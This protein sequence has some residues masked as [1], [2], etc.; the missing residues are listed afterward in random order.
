MGRLRTGADSF[1]V[2]QGAVDRD[3]RRRPRAGP[4]GR[5]RLARARQ[6]RRR[7]GLAGRRRRARRHPRS[8]RR[9]RTRR[10]CRR[11]S[12]CTSA[13]VRSLRNRA[14]SPWRSRSWPKRS[15]AHRA[16]WPD[17]CERHEARNGGSTM[18]L[19]T[20][21]SYRFARSRDDLALT[22][23]E[24]LLGGGTWLF[25]E[26]QPGVDRPRRP[27]AHGLA[28]LRVTAEGLRIGATCTIA[29]LVAFAGRGP[30]RR[31]LGRG[32]AVPRCRE[33]AA[34]LVQ[35]LEH[36]DRRRQRLPVVLPPAPMISLAVGAR[37][38]RRSSGRPTAASAAAPVAELVTG[39]GTN[40]LAARRRAARGRP[41]ARTRCAPRTGVPQD[42]AS[43]LGRSGAR[44]DRPGRR[45]RRGRVHRHR[46]DPPPGRA[47]LSRAAGRRDAR[48]ADVGAIA[49][50]TTPTRTARPTGARGV[51]IELAAGRL[52][53]SR[54]G[55]AEA[56]A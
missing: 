6:A 46:R 3:D 28:A 35:D 1:S 56:P 27:H 51:S 43:P 21:T 23:G 17:G 7:R 33:R 42:R 13:G 53:A 29:E 2:R 36:R 34:G 40:A 37:R 19:N 22:P 20:V 55:P 15:R 10:V 5:D 30:S 44:G 39:N 52:R 26:P 12:A 18:D 47:A 38:R 16:S 24:K 45:R 4:P 11:S 14:S 48:R 49:T 32:T 31:R 50:G 9:A 8:G 25:S 54:S 41:A